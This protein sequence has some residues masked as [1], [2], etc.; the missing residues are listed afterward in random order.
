MK[1]KGP[2][3]RA[4]LHSMFQI[5]SDQSTSY[6]SYRQGSLSPWGHI[7]DVGRIDHLVGG[8]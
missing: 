8:I 3:F 5:K 4:Y 6:S 2:T 1:E 7:P